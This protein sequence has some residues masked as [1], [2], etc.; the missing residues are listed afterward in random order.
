MKKKDDNPRLINR[1]ISWLEFNSRVLDEA[2]DKN[3]PLLE[4][5]KFLAI[6]S[7]N[8]DEFFMVRIA[9]I[10]QQASPDAEAEELPLDYEPEELLE[11]LNSRIKT[12]VRRQYRYLNDDIL[13]ELERKG[14][15]ITEFGKLSIEQ[16]EELKKFYH[17][18]IEPVL[19]PIGFDQS[20][21]FPIIRNCCLEILVRLLKEGDDSEKFAIIEVPP[22]I[23]RFIPVQNREGQ[24]I[25]VSAEG[26]I[27]QNLEV[28][29]EGCTIIETSFFR[30][31]RDMDFSVD[32]EIIADLLSEMQIELQKRSKR[33]VI[34]LEVSSTMSRISRNW[35]MEKLHGDQEDLFSA[36]GILD[37]KGLFNLISQCGGLDLNDHELP[38][39]PSGSLMPDE[40]I[41]ACIK[42]RGAFL[43]HHPYESF[44]PVVKM[45]EEA[46]NDPDVLA[47]KQT[48]YRVGG[49]SPVVGALARAA[50][51]GKQVTVLIELKARFDEQSNIKWA[52][53][54]DEA[55]AHVIYGIAGLK[56]HCKALLVIRKEKNGIK[57][58]IHLSTGNYNDS[59]AKLYTDIGLFS[60]DPVLAADISSLFNV[61]TGFSQPPSW[62]KIIVAPFAL[63][64]KIKYLIE[65]EKNL[66]TKENP[67]YIILKVNS[68][69][70]HELIESLYDAARNHVRIDLIVRGIC[71]INPFVEKTAQKNIKVISVVD[72]F[73]EHSRIYYFA[74]NRKAEFYV[75]SADVMPRNLD[76]RI[77]LLFP[78]E[79]DDLK[80]E[81]MYVLKAALDDKRK[82]RRLI[83]PNKYSRTDKA[84]REEKSRSQ[85][86]LYAYYQ[87]RYRKHVDEL[88]GPPAASGEIKVFKKPPKDVT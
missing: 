54:L 14:V 65:R 11:K 67:G 60:D 47:I 7:S 72:R 52:L 32:E 53:E 25:F 42:R 85:L 73:L 77:E 29:L 58:Y 88:Q 38:P 30:I 51:N 37:L 5:A 20:H 83:G 12:L 43:V 49:D 23:P 63:R 35:L 45:I 8:L 59:T 24:K 4:R 10:R 3:N 44:D 33:K 2:A 75:G 22:S 36:S 64:D 21:P 31:A 18:E 40:S 82:G 68:L 46:A 80:S 1:D 15:C 76:K 70:D 9:A 87:K 48:L 61:I 50:R 16:K 69:I 19:T 66:S 81:L 79:N 13:P 71:G 17:S 84:F 62:N 56:V 39:L 74:N 41:F 55:G 6:F 27:A 78:V 26:L 86:K 57:R 28:L 34:K